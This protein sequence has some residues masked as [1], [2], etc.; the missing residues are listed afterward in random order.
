ML[1]DK[2]VVGSDPIRLWAVSTS[3]S[4]SIS[5][6]CVLLQVPHGGATLI[7]FFIKYVEQR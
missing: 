2:E 6:L 4:I 7:I 5:Q 3:L 1:G